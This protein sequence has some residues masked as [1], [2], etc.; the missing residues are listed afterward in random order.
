MWLSGLGTKFPTLSMHNGPGIYPGY[1]YI[2][3]GYSTGSDH[4]MIWGGGIYV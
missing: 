2:N 4:L 1:I 3:T